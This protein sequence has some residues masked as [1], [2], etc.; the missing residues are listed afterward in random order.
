ME[1]IHFVDT[2]IRDGHQ[3]LWAE[4]MTTGM[5]L[6]IAK[7]LDNAGYEGIELIAGSHLKKTV[8]ELREDPWERVRLV[9]KLITKTPL[10]V[11]S[12]PV[13]SFEYNPPSMFCLFLERMAAY[14]IREARTSDEWNDYESWKFRVRVA[15][16]LG[17]RVILNLIYSVSPKHTDEYFAER[18]RQAVSLHPYRLCLKDPGGLLTPERMQTLVPVIFE[19]AGGIPVELHTHC[20]TGL[21]PLCCLEAMKLGIRSINTALPPLA[22]DSSN[23]SLFNVAKNARALGYATPIDEEVLKPVSR[24]F[25]AIAK[26]EGFT[27]GAP[28]EYDYAQYQHQV[29]G[30]M[31]S[32]LRHQLG[33]VGLEHKFPEALEE[34]IRVRKEFGY[35][36]MVTPLSQFVGSQAAINVIVG[37]RYKEVTDQAIKFALGHAGAEGARDM[38]PNV[39]DKILD[40]PRAKEWAKWK[41][42]DPTADEMRRRLGAEGTSDEELLLR[43]IV[44]KEDIDAMRAN[45]RPLEYLNSDQPLVNLL[46]ELAKRTRN[47]QIQVHTPGFSVTLEKRATPAAASD[48]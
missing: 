29:P 39:K 4:N 32:N 30:G 10:R 17:L 42:D 40:R 18:T 27:I 26:R 28:V 1:T 23:P 11:I 13:N 41:P 22:D 9:S 36:I 31:L 46:H 21:G 5:M 12:G 8:R 47:R 37:A 25:T 14:G 48:S 35:P 34:T 24:H 43:W 38:D 7:N 16:S 15:H 6:P 44:G 2:T 19:N 3:S 45:P 33:K 20:T